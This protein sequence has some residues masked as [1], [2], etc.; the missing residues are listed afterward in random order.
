MSNDLIRSKRI[1]VDERKVALR[2]NCV[3]HYSF[4]YAT[5]IIYSVIDVLRTIVFM[6]LKRNC[7]LNHD[8][9]C[10]FLLSH[11]SP[12]LLPVLLVSTLSRSPD[13][14]NLADRSQVYRR[15]RDASERF[16]RVSMPDR[17]FVCREERTKADGT[18]R[19]GSF[20]ALLSKNGPPYDT[21]RRA[22]T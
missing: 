21:L 18:R 13:L 4:V 22:G 6:G 3:L 7:P 20:C 8:R 2:S 14:S 10:R 16:P 19:R 12:T 15:K 17:Q 11:I 9:L 1:K 5:Q